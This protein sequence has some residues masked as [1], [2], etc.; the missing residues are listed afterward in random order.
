MSAKLCILITAGR[1]TNHSQGNVAKHLP[2]WIDRYL[3][4]FGMQNQTKKNL[5]LFPPSCAAK[6]TLRDV[7]ASASNST[8]CIE[9]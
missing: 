2:V 1:C 8:Q 7:T 9:K 3:N 6:S 5:V 4:L